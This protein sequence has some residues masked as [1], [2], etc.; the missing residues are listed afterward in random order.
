MPP[1][2]GPVYS[3]WL[4][5]RLGVSPAAAAVSACSAAARRLTALQ[6]LRLEL[7]PADPAGSLDVMLHALLP[8]TDQQLTCLELLDGL[9]A[10]VP[11]CVVQ[12]RGLRRLLVGDSR[13]QLM[14]LPDGPYLEAPGAFAAVGSCCEGNAHT[15]L[16]TACKWT[17]NPQH[18]WANWRLRAQLPLFC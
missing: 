14:Q 11:P 7:W 17:C 12:L 16:S 5:G 2:G 8:C 15:G 10:Q 3:L 18:W 6:K 9:A 13:L 4:D 1:A